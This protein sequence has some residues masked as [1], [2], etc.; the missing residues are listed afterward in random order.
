MATL[1]ES[2]LFIYLISSLVIKWLI[3]AA[4]TDATDKDT[5]KSRLSE[6]RLS[7]TTGLF[8]DDGQ[9][10]IFLYYLLQ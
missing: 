2:G 10:R 9:S 4:V 6:R 3:P 1:Y 8:E 7:E 5:V